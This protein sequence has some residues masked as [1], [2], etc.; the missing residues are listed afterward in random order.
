MK[1]IFKLVTCIKVFDFLKV[2]FAYLKIN[3]HYWR[4]F[5]KYFI[6]QKAEKLAAW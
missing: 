2:K 1:N 5:F 3:A 6:L 4:K